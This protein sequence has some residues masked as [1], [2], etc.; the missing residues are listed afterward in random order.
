[1]NRRFSTRAAVFCWGEGGGG[2]GE[3]P[4]CN[5]CASDGCSTHEHKTPLP[6]DG[7]NRTL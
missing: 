6:R 3:G 4:L 2:G 7:V 5:F 1:M